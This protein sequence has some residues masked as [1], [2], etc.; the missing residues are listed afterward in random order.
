MDQ[1]YLVIYQQ[2]N[3]GLLYRT[4]KTTPNIKVGSYT[5]MGWKVLAIQRLNKGK[6]LSADDYTTLLKH[7][8]RVGKFFNLLDRYDTKKIIEIGILLAILKINV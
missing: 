3:G 4:R 5:S 6:V 2:R 7:R 8:N 1:R